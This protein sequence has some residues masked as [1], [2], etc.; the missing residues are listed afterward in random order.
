MYRRNITPK[1][2]STHPRGVRRHSDLGSSS[3]GNFNPRTRVGC[4]AP[5]KHTVSKIQAF[6]STH[7]R[8]VR[9]NVTLW[10]RLRILFQSTHPRGVRHAIIR[11]AQYLRDFNPR[12]RVGCDVGLLAVIGINSYFNPRTRVG[13]DVITPARLICSFE[14]QSTHP[15]GVR[16]LPPL[17]ATYRIPISIHAPAW[18]ATA[19][20][21][22]SRSIVCHFNPRTRVGC[23][24]G[25]ISI[26]EVIFYFNPRTRVGCD[27]EQAALAPAGA[28][29]NPRTRVGCDRLGADHY[30]LRYHFNPRTRVGCDPLSGASSILDRNFNPRTRVGCDM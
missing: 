16:P 3:V 24:H 17:H 29:F 7:P 2:Q 15:R 14:F 5:K 6:Q 19:W 30:A 1:F 26:K 12:T 4:D 22:P 21:L 10:Y 20:H 27:C 9:Q 8:G 23:D 25:N 28:H 18:G 13:C 11:D